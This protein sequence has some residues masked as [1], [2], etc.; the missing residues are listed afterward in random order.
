K[1]VN[2][3]GGNSRVNNQNL[4]KEVMEKMDLPSLGTQG[5]SQVKQAYKRYLENFDTF[6]R[7]LGC[8][9]FSSPRESMVT[10]GSDATARPSRSMIRRHSNTKKDSSSEEDKDDKDDESDETD[11]ES[12]SD[13][14]REE[15]ENFVSQLYKFMEENGS[16]ILKSPTVGRA[17][18]DLYQLFNVVQ[19]LGGFS[20]VMNQNQWKEVANKMDL[21]NVT[22]QTPNLLRA[23][24]KRYLESY[25]KYHNKHGNS[26]V[27]SRTISRDS[28]VTHETIIYPGGSRTESITPARGGRGRV[29]SR[30]APQKEMKE[31]E[32]SEEESDEDS[33]PPQSTNK[34]DGTEGRNVRRQSRQSYKDLS[35]EE[36]IDLTDSSDDE[37]KKPSNTI[38]KQ[39]PKR[40]K[41]KDHLTSDEEEK[42]ANTQVPKKR[43][44]VARKQPV[45]KDKA[46]ER[47]PVAPA[48]TKR[49]TQINAR[50][51]SSKTDMKI[52]SKE[53]ISDDDSDDS[54]GGSPI[55]KPK[56]ISEIKPPILKDDIKS[57][58][59]SD[60]SEGRLVI[61]SSPPKPKINNNARKANTRKGVGKLSSDCSDDSDASHNSKKIVNSSRR[62]TAHKEPTAS[63]RSTAVKEKK[64]IYGF[65][66][67][68]SEE[69][70][71]N[72]S[73]GKKREVPPTKQHP[74]SSPSKDSKMIYDFSDDDSDE[75][76]LVISDIVKKAR[77]SSRTSTERDK[78]NNDIYSNE[79][80]ED[81]S[82][83]SNFEKKITP[84][85]RKPS[86]IKEKKNNENIS[87][88]DD[89]DDSSEDDTE[90]KDSFVA[91]LF[92]FTESSGNPINEEPKVGDHDLDLYKLYKVVERH[93]GSTRV[94]NQN[95]WHDVASN[96]GLAELPGDVAA[97]I[98]AA[99]R[100]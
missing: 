83:A 7:K 96:M 28:V 90:A 100:K 74:I 59:S 44:P 13:E 50:K 6:N 26:S 71:S 10:T 57:D 3:L 56:L 69:K 94:N 39:P 86:N 48:A 27:I 37:K 1:V 52:K 78:K 63:K 15:K 23:A 31:I 89:S 30:Q 65:S 20:R 25:E 21:K 22:A 77:P 9:V 43:G 66:S 34:T 93:G 61:S 70:G 38:K 64:K 24:Y 82:E 68:D 87:D 11:T 79:E 16:P 91:Q 85:S 98:K 35:D 62:N 45:Q 8:T 47:K 46:N 97:Q 42:V 14:C 75:D 17:N 4:W 36:V 33:D 58:E 55:S 18:L 88:T 53:Y 67:D 76:K 2:K 40:V 5:P 41:K 80:S 73:F 72:G 81:D 92:S 29:A 99:Y 51:P 54:T 12:G 95:L 49:T 32:S 60:D 84:N 19:K